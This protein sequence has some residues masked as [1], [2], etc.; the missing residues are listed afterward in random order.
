LTG[1]V[2]TSQAAQNV[3]TIP[4]T[5]QAIVGNATTVMPTANGFLTCWPSDAA[6]RPLAATSNFQSGR[7]FNRYYSVGLG[8]DGAFKLYAPATTNL[9]ID[10]SGY[11]AP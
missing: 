5:A 8:A 10:V 2:E 3:C 1:G 9:V 4:N 6:S 7:N 11:F